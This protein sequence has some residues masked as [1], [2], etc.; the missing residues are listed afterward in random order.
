M[1]Q[2]IPPALNAN[3]RL[4]NPFARDP[5]L[6]GQKNAPRHQWVSLSSI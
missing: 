2:G 1:E 3:F 5:N 6:G 4:G